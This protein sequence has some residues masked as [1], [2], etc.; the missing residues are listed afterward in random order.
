[1]SGLSECKAHIKLSN[2]VLGLSLVMMQVTPLGIAI[3]IGVGSSYH[4][5]GKLALG[6]QGAFNS[7]SAGIL[8]YNGLVDLLLPTFLSNTMLVGNYLMQFVA[9]AF[10][11]TG[12]ACMSL[13]AKW[14]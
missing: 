1:M 5:N 8:I 3:G 6:F 14:A 11:F 12:Y 4:S 9:M 13:L 10:M 2:K 7:V